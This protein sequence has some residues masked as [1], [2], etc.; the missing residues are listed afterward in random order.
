[1]GEREGD[2]DM[3]IDLDL[4]RG[5]VDREEGVLLRVACLPL[6]RRSGVMDLRVLRRIGD[7]LLL[8]L[9]ESSRLLFIARRGG[10]RERES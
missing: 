1:M 9:R 3:D 8:K 6:E 7:L 2:R 5:L 10:E 4:E